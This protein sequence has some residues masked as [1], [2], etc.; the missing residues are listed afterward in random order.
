MMINNSS[1]SSFVAQCKFFYKKK[2]NKRGRVQSVLGGDG[3]GD[4]V[5]EITLE[6]VMT[7]TQ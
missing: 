7:M 5:M 2:T 6:Q 3:N 1:L 4:G